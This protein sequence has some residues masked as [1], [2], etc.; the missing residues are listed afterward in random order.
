MGQTLLSAFWGGPWFLW[1]LWWC[2]FFVI[3]GKKLFKDNVIF[4]IILCIVAFVVPDIDNT[5]VYKFMFPIFLLA[6]L[7]NEYDLK[8]KLKRIYTHRAFAFTCIIVFFVLLKYYN[9]DSYIYTTGYA[10]LGKNVTYQL[11]IDFFRFF[12][13]L[14]GSFSVMC[15]VHAFMEIVPNRVNK[16]LAYVGSCTL[17]IY[18]LSGYLF[19]EVLKLLPISGLNYVYTFIEVVCVLVCTIGITS[20]LKKCKTTNKLLLGGR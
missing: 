16:A 13:G 15:V 6:Y 3:L 17:G 4:Y 8:T 19:D 14:V 9:F 7:F 12:I 1:A 2:S 18:I 10:L 20:L 11:H 5:A